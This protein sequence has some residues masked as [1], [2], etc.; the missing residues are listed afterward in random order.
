MAAAPVYAEDIYD[1]ATILDPYPKYKALRDMGPLVYLQAH[2]LYA[3]PRYADVRSALLNHKDFISG[4]GIAGFKWPK[5]IDVTNSIASD[6]PVHS[7]FRKAIDGPLQPR[8]LEQLRDAI[9][10]AAN[11]L[12]KRLT[13]VGEF[14]LMADFARILPVSIVSSLVGLPEKGRERML[15][16]AAASFNVLGVNNERTRES[17]GE[18]AAMV[19]YV[20]EEC[21]PDTVK[22]GGWT[23]LIWEAVERGE[24][25]PQEA[26]IIHIDLLAPSLDTTIFATGHLIHQLSSNPDQWA[27]LKE[28]PSLVPAAIDEAVRLEAPIRAF[29]RVAAR[30]I[31]F[32]DAMLPAGSRVLVM[33]AS[34]NRDE[35][36]WEEPDSY[37][38]E[39]KGLGGHLGFGQ[40]RHICV[41]QHL[42]RLEMRSLLEAIVKNVETI[43]VGTPVYA[44]NNVLRGFAS[45]PVRFVA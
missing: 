18:V 6:E 32:E 39:R 28:D 15:D 26:G 33:Y 4:E 25:T 10:T 40:G 41:G 19:R 7:R 17:Y 11:D 24:L 31:Q 22:P 23:S 43:E 27:R 42:A 34:A 14:D 36:R 21:G 1:E 30:D 20:Q 35:R 8:A 45:A 29:A 13:G 38:I 9:Q 3:L 16:W 12:V 37:R 44:I 5:E 2:D